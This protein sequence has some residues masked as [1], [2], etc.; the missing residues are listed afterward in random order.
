MR[1]NKWTSP[2]QHTTSSTFDIIRAVENG[3]FPVPVM[4]TFHPQRWHDSFF[5]W[6]SELMRQKVKNMVKRGVFET[7]MACL[8]FINIRLL[9]SYLILNFDRL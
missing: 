3:T 1:Q 9:I 4:M 2:S 8:L 6:T 5:G 7:R